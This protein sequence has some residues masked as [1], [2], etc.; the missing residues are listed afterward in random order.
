MAGIRVN[1]GNRVEEIVAAVQPPS[2][3]EPDP[4]WNINAQ[5]LDAFDEAAPILFSAAAYRL[6]ETDP[7]F[8]ASF[9]ERFPN[10]ANIFR[11]RIRDG[12]DALRRM[13]AADD[14][15]TPAGLLG[16][17][18]IFN[19]GGNDIRGQA[20]LI[21]GMHDDLLPFRGNPVR[22]WAFEPQSPIENV[23]FL[24]AED[25]RI[26][27]DAMLY[28][29]AAAGMQSVP[30]VGAAPSL[31]VDFRD[32]FSS[33][34]ATISYLKEAGLVDPRY[35]RD[36]AVW[37][38]LAALG[39]VGLTALGAQGLTRLPRVSRALSRLQPGALS[40]LPV[41]SRTL[42]RRVFGAD[43]RPDEALKLGSTF[44]RLGE[45]SGIPSDDITRSI[46]TQLHRVRPA[47]ASFVRSVE[48]RLDA[49][50]SISPDEVR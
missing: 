28:Y 48:S 47:E 9:D 44:R 34:N 25:R 15:D 17:P 11:L 38:H 24:S 49:G 45:A 41:I 30:Y 50:E 40:R 27:E 21:A 29:L 8:D 33:R 14:A 35:H 23:T 18:S 42:N 32:I 12:A 13:A 6:L 19:P 46:F 43:L 1:M 4:R 37:E 20:M 39:G 26:E 2:S 36:K 16:N 22:G 7:E 3:D 31:A 5:L 10:S